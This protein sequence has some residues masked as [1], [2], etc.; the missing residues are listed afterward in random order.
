MAVILRTIAD[1]LE[2]ID[3][4]LLRPPVLGLAARA[5]GFGVRGIG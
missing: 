3:L 2:A 1:W 4:V 5:L